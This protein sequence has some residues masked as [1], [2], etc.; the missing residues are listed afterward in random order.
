MP[1]STYGRRAGAVKSADQGARKTAGT[2]GKPAHFT[3]PSKNDAYV[4]ESLAERLTTDALAL[5]PGVKGFRPQPYT[6]DLIDRVLLPTA[7][8]VRT[9]YAKHAA[10]GVI[11]AF[12]TP[13]FDLEWT[14]GTHSAVEVKLEG[15]TGDAQYEEKLRD[16]TEVLSLHGIELIHVV[17]PSYWRHPLRANLPLLHQAKLRR[18]LAPTTETLVRVELLA[19]AGASTLKEYCSGLDFDNRMAPVLIVHGAL[20]VDVLQNALLNTTPA[21]PAMGSLDHLSFLRR[22]AR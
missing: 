15:Y 22:L 13:D 17:I 4:V 11:A 18:D 19:A 20:N 5:D 9:A 21:K 14:L 8:A 3:L 10:G 12:Y 7:D 1:L 6:V 2:Y 16:A